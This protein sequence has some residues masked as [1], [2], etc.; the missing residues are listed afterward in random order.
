MTYVV[1]RAPTRLADVALV[2]SLL[3]CN[4]LGRVLAANASIVAHSQYTFSFV[5]NRLVKG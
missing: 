3:D 5:L 2:C 1:K 4:T